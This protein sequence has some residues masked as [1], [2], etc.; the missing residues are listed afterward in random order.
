MDCSVLK[1][2]KWKQR[3]RGGRH[4]TNGTGG[5]RGGRNNKN[6][7]LF[8]KKRSLH[9]CFLVMQC[10]FSNPDLVNYIGAYL[11]YTNYA[12]LRSVYTMTNAKNFL[13]HPQMVK[14]HV[15][16]VSRCTDKFCVPWKDVCGISQTTDHVRKE[17]S[18]EK[19][20]KGK[21]ERTQKKESFYLL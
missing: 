3:K 13:Y 20:E 14:N 19:K 5:K 21:E 7:R 9:E 2:G 10:V 12:A 8:L 18:L 6:R 15:W 16:E 11:S 1:T 4:G 17:V